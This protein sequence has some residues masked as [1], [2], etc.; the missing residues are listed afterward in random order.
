MSGDI[1]G[2]YFLGRMLQHTETVE[3]VETVGLFRGVQIF[4]GLLSLER[5]Y[6]LPGLFY[7]RIT[8]N[9]NLL[10]TV[11]SDFQEVVKIWQKRFA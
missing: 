4:E 8:P 7:K 11:S 2:L 1:L 5:I 3:K 10:G 9:S 6:E